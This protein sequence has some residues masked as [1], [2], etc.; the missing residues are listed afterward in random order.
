[1]KKI[2][3]ILICL[4]GLV[5]FT[6]CEH[7][8]IESEQKGE[9]VIDLLFELDGCK[10]YRFNDAGKRIYWSNCHGNVSYE[11]YV[12]TGKSGYNEIILALTTE[13]CNL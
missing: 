6:S 8:A 3:Y 2:Y 11:K 7:D 10:M 12:S 4:I 5:L 1:M 13:N 9:I